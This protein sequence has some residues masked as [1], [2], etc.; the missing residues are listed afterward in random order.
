MIVG[1][2]SQKKLGQMFDTVRVPWHGIIVKVYD[3]LGRDYMTKLFDERKCKCSIL[4][5]WSMTNAQR[6]IERGEKAS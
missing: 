3:Q 1:Y 5:Y 4:R 6:E 2:V